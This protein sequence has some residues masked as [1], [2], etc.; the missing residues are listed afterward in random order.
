[1]KQSPL[2][3]PLCASTSSTDLDLLAKLHIVGYRRCGRR[4][5]F[6][7]GNEAWRRGGRQ[8]GS[9]GDFT[10]DPDHPLTI[11]PISLSGCAVG[12]WQR[13]R[14]VKAA[15]PQEVLPDFVRLCINKMDNQ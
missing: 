10:R 6:R 9:A 12:G 7:V 1:M 15:K 13:Q 4:H 5:R 11:P 14:L 3:P 2:P 8:G